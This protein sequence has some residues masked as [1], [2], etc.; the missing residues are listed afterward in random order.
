MRVSALPVE[1]IREALADSPARNRVLI[2]DCCYSGTVTLEHQGADDDVVLAQVELSGTYTLAAAPATRVAV[3]EPGAR[4]T[5]FTEL[6]LAA[7]TAGVPGPSELLTL[8]VLYRHLLRTANARG[9]PRPQ[10]RGTGTAQDLAL[11][12]NRAYRPA[13]AAD[14]PAE[15][16]AG[17]PPD[18]L[19]DGPPDGPVG[20]PWVQVQAMQ[21]VAELLAGVDVPRSRIDEAIAAAGRATDE[22]SRDA[23][24]TGIVP[25]LARHDPAAARRLAREIADP[26]RRR[27]ALREVAQVLSTTNLTAALDVLAES[28]S[29]GGSLSP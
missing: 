4:Y 13:P 6:L 15:A 1:V 22:S 19:V 17:A 3:Y 12:R 10:Q 20:G 5:A 14:A 29:A 26:E 21:M 9:L 24:L 7:L 8:D 16:P 28:R 25:A 11:A 18:A 27:R 2:L 23:M